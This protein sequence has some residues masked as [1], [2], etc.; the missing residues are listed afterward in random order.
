MSTQVFTGTIYQGSAQALLARIRDDEGQYP[1]AFEVSSITVKVWDRLT[2]LLVSTV[3][4]SPPIAVSDVLLTDDRWQED[5]EGY[6][7]EIKLDGS[8]F[9][10]GNRQYQVECKVDPNDAYGAGSPFYVVWRL[11]CIEVFSE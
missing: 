10:L 6:N 8:N 4:I 1:M 7:L 9:P 2:G 5:S 3:N 11:T